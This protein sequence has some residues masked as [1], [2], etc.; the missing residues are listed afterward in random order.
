MLHLNSFSRCIKIFAKLQVSKINQRVQIKKLSDKSSKERLMN[1]I[2]YLSELSNEIKIATQKTIMLQVGIMKLC[3]RENN[4]EV[5]TTTN[6]AEVEKN[7][8]IP[9][10]NFTNE[11]NDES[12]NL[13]GRIS[14]LEIKLQKTIDAV[15]KLLA[16]PQIIHNLGQNVDN[17]ME[18]KTNYGV[19]SADNQNIKNLL[20]TKKSDVNVECW[21]KIVSSI[22]ET[23]KVMLYSNL[24]NSRACELN[25]MTIGIIF[26]EG[27]TP[28]GKSVIAKSE[29]I[30]EL[31]KLVSMEYGKTM[32]IR[33]IDNTNEKSKEATVDSIV[34]DLDL[35]LNI[36]D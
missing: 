35:P 33:L 24:A 17:S 2:F 1:I 21:G 32:Q 26:P 14:N 31:T 9:S 7:A 27:L 16:D 23:G 28:F 22:K 20:T 29:N 25:D 36:I 8:E 15:Q 5:S 6:N 11:I 19:R 3:S 30:S 12:K 13:D 34:K 10:K 4:S 18:K